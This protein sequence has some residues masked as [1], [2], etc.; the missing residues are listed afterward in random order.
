MKLARYLTENELVKTAVCTLA[1]QLGPV[2][3]QRFLSISTA[4]KADAVQRHRAWQ[5][6]LDKTAFF[7]QVFKAKAQ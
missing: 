3:T 5:A 4:R 2:E 7:N 1:K 6:H